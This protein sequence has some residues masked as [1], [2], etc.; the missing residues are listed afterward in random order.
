M[1]KQIF[2]HAVNVEEE[3]YQPKQEFHHVETKLDEPLE[4]ELLDA[5]LEQALKPKSG[6]GKTLLKFT[7]LLFF[8]LSFK[9]NYNAF[10]MSSTRSF[11][12]PNSICVFS[13]KNNGFCTPA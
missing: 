13:L 3:Q 12:S 5:Q 4:G 2:E 10:K 8:S 6:F 1:E 7:A 9:A 11:A